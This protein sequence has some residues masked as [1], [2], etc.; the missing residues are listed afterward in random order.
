[1]PF[2]VGTL[3]FQGEMVAICNSSKIKYAAA[4]HATHNKQKSPS[5][6]PE[7]TIVQ[8]LLAVFRINEYHDDV[9][10]A[11]CLLAQ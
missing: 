4:C 9:L 2:P 3:H 6:Q 7:V 10:S 5:T 1:M 8:H 11:L